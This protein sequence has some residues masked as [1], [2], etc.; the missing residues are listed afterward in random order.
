MAAS[1]T[2]SSSLPI[3]GI[4]AGSVVGG[5]AITA[6]IVFAWYKVKTT[7]PEGPPGAYSE[8]TEPGVYSR[9]EQVP[10]VQISTDPRQI[11][12]QERFPSRYPQDLSANL[13]SDERY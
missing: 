12:Y 7:R 11:A 9:K 2:S 4:V 5:I 13:S 8:G 6:I 3:G 1:G 10:P